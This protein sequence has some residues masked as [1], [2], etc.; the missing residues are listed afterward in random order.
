MEFS[1]SDI[2][3][4]RRVTLVLVLVSIIG[5]LGMTLLLAPT[6]AWYIPAGTLFGV[7]SVL[8][9]VKAHEARG[10]A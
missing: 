8:F 2:Q 4:L 3:Q 6:G 5:L 7:M 9:W 10:I 1:Y